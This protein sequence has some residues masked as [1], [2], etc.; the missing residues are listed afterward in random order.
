MA[1]TGISLTDGGAGSTLT[2]AASGGTVIRS[3][4]IVIDGGGSVITTGIKGFVVVPF[5]GTIT[6]ATLLSTD[7]AVTAGSIVIDVW[8]D[9]YANYPPTVADTITA[10]AK[11]TLSSATKSQDSTL[12]GWT[13]GITAGDILGFKVDSVTTLTHVTLVLQVS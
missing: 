5:G 2:I 6:K 7:P 9:T 1:G 8:K 11:P 12:T 10:S 13:T 4:G 3:V